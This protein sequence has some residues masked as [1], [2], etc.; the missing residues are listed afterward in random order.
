MCIQRDQHQRISEYLGHLAVCISFKKYQFEPDDSLAI[1]RHVEDIA[2]AF[3]ENV[4]SVESWNHS[5]LAARKMAE[6][7]TKDRQKRHLLEAWDQLLCGD[8]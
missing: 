7:Y 6:A 1:A 5:T 8:R 2:K 4:E 3:Q